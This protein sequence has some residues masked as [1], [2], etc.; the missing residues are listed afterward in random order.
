VAERPA[1][2]DAV[3]LAW[4]G[5]CPPVGT[6]RVGL[7]DATGRVLAEPIAADRDSPAHD[8]S[9]MD[10]YA[11]R[12]GDFDD[13][14][15][16]A[17]AGEVTT[18]S[19]PPALPP[20]QALR[21]FTGGCV[22]AGAE[23]VIKREDLAETRELIE[24]Q[25]DR[26]TLSPGQHI[27]R[28]GENCLAG[29]PVVA[30]GCRCTAAVAG[31][32]AGFGA[33]RLCVFRRVRVGLMVTGDELLPPDASPEPWQVRDSNGPAVSAMLGS[34]PWIEA[35]SVERGTD[36]PKE[37]TRRMHGLLE[38]CDA[39]VTTGGVSMGDHDYIPAVVRAVGG[40]VVFHKLP[41]RPG[42]P[43][44]GGIGPSG[45]PIIAL[46]GN[47][48]SAM[49]TLRRFGLVALRRVAG[50]TDPLPPSASVEVEGF[51][52]KPLGLWAYR[53]VRLMGGG[54]ASL[55]VS[56]GSGDYAS[57]A[58]S[59][60]LIEAPPGTMELARAAYYPWAID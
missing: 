12:L 19:A 47:P 1:H 27:R 2:P 24:L 54:R 55:V 37:L 51:D 59:D 13:A 53:L 10:G 8:V 14:G 39:V 9:A 42:R 7:A 57:A 17:V 38:R 50:F 30:A 36:D 44:L 43:L 22:P 45:Q 15:R 56:R 35:V 52:A 32:A 40:E 5:R 60:G 20:G 58:A 34:V 31:V 46:P 28:R 16:M 18:G 41:V 33:T 11:L 21:I 25:V 48:V 6:E 26:A 23:L 29:S 4:A 49:A 3:V